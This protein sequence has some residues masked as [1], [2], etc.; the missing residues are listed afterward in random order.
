MQIKELKNGY[1]IEVEPMCYTLKRKRMA[2][3]KKGEEK[4]V[5]TIHGYHNSLEAALEKFLF[6]NHIDKNADAAVSLAEYVKLVEKSNK[7]AVR[8][9][10]KALKEKE[11]E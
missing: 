8:A 7:E 1:Y 6:L 9:I 10:L 4:E 11:N 2:K 5:E 3:N